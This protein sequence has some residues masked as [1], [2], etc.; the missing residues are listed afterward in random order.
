MSGTRDCV[1]ENDM[2]LGGCAEREP[3]TSYKPTNAD[4]IR[5]MKDAEELAIFM[6]QRNACLRPSLRTE[7]ECE[8]Y[9]DCFKCWADWLKREAVHDK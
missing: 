5:S 3:M 4:H 2:L 7:D 6:V 1:L 9:D 8:K